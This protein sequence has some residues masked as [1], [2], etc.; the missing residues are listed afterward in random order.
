MAR[1]VNHGPNWGKVY[2]KDTKGSF[3]DFMKGTFNAG[4]DSV[5]GSGL[6]DQHY[7]SK[8]GNKRFIDASPEQMKDAKYYFNGEQVDKQLAHER[9]MQKTMIDKATTARDSKYNAQQTRRKKKKKGTL[10][11]DHTPSG[12]QQNN[13]LGL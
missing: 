11:S 13:L 6:V 12:S 4:T 1:T 2:K 10:V 9:S 3:L 7:A 8:W 5:R